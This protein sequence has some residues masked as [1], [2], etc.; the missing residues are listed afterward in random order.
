MAVEEEINMAWV[1][2]LALIIL[3]V[4]IGFYLYFRPGVQGGWFSTIVEAFKWLLTPPV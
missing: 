2:I 4:M 1:I 3:M